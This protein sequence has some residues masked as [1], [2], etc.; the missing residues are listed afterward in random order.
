MV[1]V[2]FTYMEI[3]TMAR[4]RKM[5]LIIR[6]RSMWLDK[7]LQSWI[8]IRK[9]EFKSYNDYEE[10]CFLEASEVVVFFD[11]LGLLLRNGLVDIGLISQLFV[12][13]RVWKKMQL[14]VEGVRKTADDPRFYRHFEYLY[15]EWKKE[16]R[17]VL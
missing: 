11:S 15:N 17:E 8:T 7:V 12:V 14:F 13:G 3:R 1:G 10:K 9:I 6:I 5:D 4:A 2:A 16:N